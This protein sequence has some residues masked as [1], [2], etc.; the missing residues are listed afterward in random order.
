MT[1]LAL[2]GDA[3]RQP[4]VP[5]SSPDWMGPVIASISGLVLGLVVV[6]F[7]YYLGV[8]R[9][10]RRMGAKWRH[11]TLPRY[12]LLISATFVILVGRSLYTALGGKI[13]ELYMDLITIAAYAMAL[14]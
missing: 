9:E 2:L 10:G 3:V 6:V 7:W 1:V 5:P 11:R 8:E 12:V 13:P 14:V 4:L